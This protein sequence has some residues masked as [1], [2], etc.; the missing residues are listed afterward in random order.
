MLCYSGLS[1]IYLCPDIPLLPIQL[2][3]QNVGA[4]TGGTAMG[5]VPFESHWFIVS[6]H[7]LLLKS[8]MTLV[9]SSKFKHWKNLLAILNG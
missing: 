1:Y 2:I 9:H 3:L 7:A 8:G 5:I 6:Y 4:T